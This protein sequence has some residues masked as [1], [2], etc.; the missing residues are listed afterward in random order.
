MPAPGIDRDTAVEQQYRDY[1]YP[2]RDPEQERVRLIATTV[3][4]LQRASTVL[5]GGRR[6]LDSLALLDAGCGT[7]D[8][9]LYM[10]VQAPRARVVALD[11]SPASLDVA[12]RRARRRGLTNIEFVQAS[13]LDLPRLGLGTFDYIVCSGVLHH[14]PEPEAGMTALV[15]VL[16]S[17]G[18]LGLML[19]GAH[20]RMPIY[21]VQD[22]L[23]RL[24][25]GEPM[26]QRVA[27]TAGL[28]AVLSPE[29]YFKLGGLDRQFADMSGS[30][31]GIVDMLLHARDRAYTVDDIHALLAAGGA[32]LLQFLRP[33]F[34]RPESYPLTD[35]MRAR[36]ARLPEHARQAV[37]ELLHGRIS[38]HEFLA[39][40]A[41][42]TP[43]APGADGD[44]AAIRPVVWEPG[45]VEAFRKLRPEPQRFHLQ[46]RKGFTIDLQLTAVDGALLSGLNNQR[47]LA[48]VMARAAQVLR[49]A[50]LRPAPADLATAW[51]RLSDE[52]TVAGSLGY[53]WT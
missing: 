31:S 1:P 10:A 34:Y 32:A 26:P 27:M 50:R 5:W 35:G 6:R 2:P 14:L 16:A 18:G 37:G 17:G 29:H 48:G 39:I 25:C 21:Q 11:R 24:D 38:K 42:T 8:S 4:D 49:P 12:R 53:A 41:G 36:V 9:C 45:L 43:D 46:S 7:G 13:L 20:G 52:F 19:Y 15:S 51:R 33:V 22:L 40:R 28:L 3:G 47:S 30:E 44:P 23:R